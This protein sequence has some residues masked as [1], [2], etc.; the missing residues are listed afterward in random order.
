MRIY[1]KNLPRQRK[2]GIFLTTTNVSSMAACDISPD[3]FAKLCERCA[4]LQLR[5]TTADKTLPR[6]PST[7]EKEVDLDWNVTSSHVA[8]AFAQG[9]DKCDCCKFLHRV[10]TW[11]EIHD[12]LA[13]TFSAKPIPVSLHYVFRLDGFGEYGLKA[14][15]IRIRP[16]MYRE[17]VDTRVFTNRKRDRRRGTS[18][19]L[20]RHGSY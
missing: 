16:G 6:N 2:R 1:F 9:S 17:P 8:H 15:R 3:Q 13:N 5:S 20:P 4:C 7:G 14:L 18:Y 12:D 19:R 10:A 11:W